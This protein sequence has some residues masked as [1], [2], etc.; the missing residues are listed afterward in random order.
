MLTDTEVRCRRLLVLASVPAPHPSSLAPASR[1]TAAAARPAVL[2][3]PT[4]S[5]DPKIYIRTGGAMAVGS[6]VFS[7]M[8]YF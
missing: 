3:T 5:M 4:F 8:F 2:P 1:G 6:V 7:C